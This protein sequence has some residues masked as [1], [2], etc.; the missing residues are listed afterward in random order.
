M[1]THIYRLA[2]LDIR[3]NATALRDTP[4]IQSLAQA[5]GEISRT[6][7]ARRENK[8]E[9]N[10]DKRRNGGVQVAALPV[11]RKGRLSSLMNHVDVSRGKWRVEFNAE[12]I[13]AETS[14]SAE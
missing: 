4:W 2:S 9:R 1:K 5:N 8:R 13:A 3:S 7:F 6:R 14:T 11:S 12:S 10:P